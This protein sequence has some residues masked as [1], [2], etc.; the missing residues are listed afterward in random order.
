MFCGP[1]PYLLQ[2]FSNRAKK[3]G[4]SS[5]S[6]PEDRA[7]GWGPSCAVGDDVQGGSL[8]PPPPPRSAEAEGRGRP[9]WGQ[10]HHT[11]VVGTGPWRDPV[12]GACLRGRGRRRQTGLGGRGT[13]KCQHLR[14]GAVA[15]AAEVEGG[16][17]P[18]VGLPEQDRPVP[19][20]CGRRS[21]ERLCPAP[22]WH[23]QAGCRGV[24]GPRGWMAGQVSAGGQGQ[25]AVPLRGPRLRWPL[26][27][28]PAW[29]TEPPVF[30]T[31][32]W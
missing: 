28:L 24:V 14:R 2:I 22:S 19:L 20:V 6:R 31:G 5:G 17:Q 12:G 32:G 9:G 27:C 21:S 23:P 15:D 4:P 26:Q 13:V 18:V 8:G 30:T 7:A 11:V 29:G 25:P 10:P 3:L 1:S 16:V